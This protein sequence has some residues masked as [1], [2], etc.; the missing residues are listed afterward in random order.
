LADRGEVAAPSAFRF[1]TRSTLNFL[2][3]CSAAP[4]R[5][6]PARRDTRRTGAKSE[7]ATPDQFIIARGC[8]CL[9]FSAKV[10]HSL[11]K[12]AIL[13]QSLPFSAN[14]CH[15]LP[16]SAIVCRPIASP[17]GRTLVQRPKATA[18]GVCLL[19]YADRVTPTTGPEVV[20]RRPQGL[21][22]SAI[23][24]HCLP[25]RP[26]RLQWLLADMP[27]GVYFAALRLGKRGTKQIP[28]ALPLAMILCPFG[29][30]HRNVARY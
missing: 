6:L 9:P 29:A 5:S 23:I 28:G 16:K 10:C 15:S 30:M 4:S 21:P 22:L 12:S 3:S 8:Q 2:L 24:C 19:L 18:H 1:S 26:G 13:C 17:W 14:V 20:H 7:A 25:L 27:R 11:P